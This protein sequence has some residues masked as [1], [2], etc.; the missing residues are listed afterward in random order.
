MNEEWFNDNVDALQIKKFTSTIQ[1]AL[2][3]AYNG[4]QTNSKNLKAPRKKSR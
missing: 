4:I 1:E 3:R 2:T